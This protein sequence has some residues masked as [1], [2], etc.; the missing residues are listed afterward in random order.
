MIMAHIHAPGKTAACETLQTTLYD[1]VVAVSEAAGAD[2]EAAITATVMH[3]LNFHH[4]RCVGDFEGYRLLC[5]TNPTSKP[6]NSSFSHFESSM[7]HFESMACREKVG[8]RSV[9]RPCCAHR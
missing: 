1:L 2:E 5:E 9:A 7:Y 6:D 4:V 8:K 3:M